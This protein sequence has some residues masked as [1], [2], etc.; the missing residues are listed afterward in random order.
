MKA[1]SGSLNSWA[2]SL[3][4]LHDLEAEE[5]GEDVGQE[6]EDKGDTH[7]PAGRP[8]E[9]TEE[10][11]ED[12]DTEGLGGETTLSLVSVNVDG[13]GALKDCENEDQPG[14]SGAWVNVGVELVHFL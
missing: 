13:G 14:E 6:G 12:G 3:G 8:A 5:D 1:V 9:T 11:A 4:L 7:Q 2:R 10:V